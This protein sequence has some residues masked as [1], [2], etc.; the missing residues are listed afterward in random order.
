MF[1]LTS[2]NVGV[3]VLF[4]MTFT[5]IKADLVSQYDHAFS[6]QLIL[7]VLSEEGAQLRLQQLPAK[8]IGASECKHTVLTH[9]ISYINHEP[10][11]MSIHAVASCNV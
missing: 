1:P 10:E 3:C 8:H 9:I 7:K 11:V 6:E 5:F 2:I 4:V